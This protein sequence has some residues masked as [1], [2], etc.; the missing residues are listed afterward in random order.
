MKDSFEFVRSCDIF[1][2]F[3]GRQKNLVIPLKPVFATGPFEKWGLDFIGPINP[4]SSA[5]H[6]FILTTTN[7]F[8]KWSEAIALKIARDEQVINILKDNIFFRFGLPVSIIS[9]NGPEFISAK[10]LKFCVDL[11][12]KHSFSSSYYPQGNGL[13]ESMNKKLIKILK[14]IIEDKPRQC[15]LNL[16]YALWE[17]RTTT[18]SSIGTTPFQLLFGQQVV[19]PIELQLTSFRLDFQQGELEE[20]PLK[21]KF[22]TLLA[23]DEQRNHSLHTIEK[24]QRTVKKYFDRKSK[25]TTFQVGQK[26]LLWDSAHADKGKHNKLQKLWIGPYVIFL[27]WVKIHTC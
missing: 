7:Y 10:F 25:N 9:D 3:V 1:K 18:K 15:H 26:V 20:P 2:R 11:N 4:P 16:T 5:G 13:V 17:D 23:I 24:R 19:L 22:Y 8:S 27:L 14:N 21:N 6:N 12:I